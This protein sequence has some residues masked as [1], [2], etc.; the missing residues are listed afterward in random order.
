MN[1]VGL[2]IGVISIGTLSYYTIQYA[3]KSIQRGDRF[4]GIMR[5]YLWPAKLIMAISLIVL[6]LLALRMLISE[7]DRLTINKES[8]SFGKGLNNP[9][10]MVPF[11]IMLIII[12]IVLFKT[13]PLCGLILLLLTLLLAGV[14][15]GF[16]IITVAM[17]CLFFYFNGYKSLAT[18]PAMAFNFVNR[19]TLL[20]L[21]MF[22]FAG[23]VMARGG[24]GEDLFN[25][26]RAFVGHITGGLGIAVAIACT[27]FGALSGSSVACAL[28]IGS[29]A[30]PI[31]VENGY[32]KST[33]A[34][35]IAATGGVGVLIPPSNA[36]I[37]YG[38]I[39]GAPI[40]TL[41]I[42]S[43]IPGLLM[44]LLMGVIFIYIVRKKE[45]K[46]L[47]KPSWKE[48]VRVTRRSIWALFMP[49]VVLGGIYSG[50]ITITEA[51]AVAAVYAVLYSIFA[52][53]LK[54]REM[55]KVL[56]ESLHNVSFLMLILIASI[57]LSK[58]VTMLQLPNNLLLYLDG[59]GIPNWIVILAV[60]VFCLF[61]GCFLDGA[62]IIALTVPIFAP[63]IQG[64]GHSLIWYGALLIVT[65][66]AA[67]VTPPVGLNLFVM[68]RVGNLDIQT[69]VKGS[70][71]FLIG[72]CIV[73]LLVAI[74]PQLTLWLPTLM[75]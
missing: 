46:V 70:I 32:D 63:V 68:Q 23:N 10:I 24:L 42:A 37:T 6:T 11:V 25:F 38:L 73:M 41:F 27:I 2:L 71:P 58:C 48:R 66:T 51:S 74:I 16:S 19:Q 50:I 4:Y 9:W 31:M 59:A 8:L 43:I 13:M 44:A 57:M 40:G 45:I 18:T 49:V 72:I 33:A 69:V 65:T 34:G 36:A 52:N 39:T 64:F 56:T 20:A 21:P 54:P 28:T 35:L 67:A 26:A 7:F 1:S 12:S 55:L 15:I 60:L 22:V 75:N 47:P 53:T 62:A 5:L 61:L 3:L 30:Y 17:A 14:P 29:V